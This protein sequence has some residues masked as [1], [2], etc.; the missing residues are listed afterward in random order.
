MDGAPETNLVPKV[1]N[2]VGANIKL[3][4]MRWGFNDD[5]YDVRPIVGS[6]DDEGHRSHINCGTGTAVLGNTGGLFA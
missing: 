1:Q 4:K 3:L 2:P 5:T 6:T